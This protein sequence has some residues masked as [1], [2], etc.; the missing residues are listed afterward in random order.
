MAAMKKQ[1]KKV[2]VSSSNGKPKD[3]MAVIAR[4]KPL[5]QAKSRT[6]KTA[7][8]LDFAAQE[9]PHLPIA[10]N[11]IVQAIDHLSR[12][13]AQDSELVKLMAKSMQGV[14]RKLMLDYNRGL[15][16]VKGMGVRATVDGD[17]VANTQ[18]RSGV[19]RL[20]GAKKSVERTRQLIDPS[21]MK[22]PAL[23]TWVQGG[24]TRMLSEMNAE[25]RLAKL[26][27]PKL[28]GDDDE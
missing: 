20:V 19:G 10:L 23:K 1:E 3:L 24:V 21:T 6:E 2:G 18:L 28:G 11:L 22:N 17:D 26:L 13:P 25:N 12:T 16:T 7:H 27:P 9:A 5:E 15:S 8:F 14:R 4:Y